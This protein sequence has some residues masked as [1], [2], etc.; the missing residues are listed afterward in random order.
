MKPTSI[1]TFLLGISLT[2]AAPV[3]VEEQVAAKDSPK[4]PG[5][6]Q[7]QSNNAWAI[8]KQI[9]TE[10]FGSSALLAC[11]AAFATALVESDLY[12]YASNAVPASL[13]YPHDKVHT[14]H[15]SVGVFQ[16]Q[17]TYYPVSKAMYPAKA[18]DMFFDAMRKV[19]D[20]KKAKTNKDIGEVCAKVQRPAAQYR[21]R[22]AKRVGEAA[23]ICKVGGIGV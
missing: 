22:Y 23:K 3:E 13:K 18:A 9:K 4:I 2:S 15:K 8:I 17:S 1:L 20:W 10:K 11:K 19:K 5:Y 12:N 7:R 16:Q 6:D 21:G 14:D